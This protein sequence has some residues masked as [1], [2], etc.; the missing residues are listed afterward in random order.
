MS[1]RLFLGRNTASPFRT[2]QI[3]KAAITV[4]SFDLRSLL[5][6]CSAEHL[7]QNI[8]KSHMETCQ[9]LR[10]ELQQMTWQA[11]LQEEVESYQSK[12]PRHLSPRTPLME[13]ACFLNP[14][15]VLSAPSPGKS[16]GSCALSK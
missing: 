7:A 6:C 4:T 2:Q 5:N 13:R 16:C 14:S 9:Y 15:S 8:S 3:H 10:E 12:V 11:F 1:T